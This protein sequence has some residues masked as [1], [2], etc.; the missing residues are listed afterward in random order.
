MNDE[1]K[2]TDKSQKEEKRWGMREKREFYDDDDH[3][4]KENRRRGRKERERVVQG[5]FSEIRISY[6]ESHR[7]SSLSWSA[8]ICNIFYPH[9]YYERKEE[10]VP[11]EQKREETEFKSDWR[12]SFFPPSWRRFSLVSCVLFLAAASDSSSRGFWC[13]LMQI[14]IFISERSVDTDSKTTQVMRED[15][16]QQK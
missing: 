10:H 2:I 16:V 9:Y 12:E 4:E 1:Q 14:L 15:E 6:G 7:S 3:Q 11:L 13:D 8:C 5:V